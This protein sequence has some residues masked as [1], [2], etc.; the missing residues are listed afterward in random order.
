MA[1]L[2]K[3][4]ANPD[5]IARNGHIA[6]AI[7]DFLARKGWKPPQLNEAI[8]LSPERSNVYVWMS[9][10]IAPSTV[11]QGKLARVMGVPITSLL[12]KELGEAAS[13]AMPQLLPPGPGPGPK[14]RDILTIT[15]ATDGSAHIRLDATLPASQAMPIVRLLLDAGLV[16][17]DPA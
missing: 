1:S 14:P 6:A 9:A 5:Q 7:R 12:P 13:Q 11:Y 4:P 15:F 2:Q 17:G 3:G 16:V 8:G 10:K